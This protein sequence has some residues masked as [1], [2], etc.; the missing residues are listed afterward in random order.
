M[1]RLYFYLYFFVAVLFMSA[2]VPVGGQF[3]RNLF[4][5]YLLSFISFTSLQEV[6]ANSAFPKIAKRLDGFITMSLY[7]ATSS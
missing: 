2:C 5:Q 6:V 7:R 1:F 4:V 3:V